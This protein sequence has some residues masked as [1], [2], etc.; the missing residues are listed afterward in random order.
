[1][2]KRVS[3]NVRKGNFSLRFPDGTTIVYKNGKKVL[4]SSPAG[5]LD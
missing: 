3:K 2:A 4:D 5:L 1:M